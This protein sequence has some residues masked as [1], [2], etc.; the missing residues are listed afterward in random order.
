MYIYFFLQK[1]ARQNLIAVVFLSAVGSCTQ[2]HVEEWRSRCRSVERWRNDSNHVISGRGMAW[3]SPGPLSG[4]FPQENRTGPDQQM[5]CIARIPKHQRLHL[6]S[7][8][9]VVVGQRESCQRTGSAAGFA[10]YF[11]E[12]SQ[13]PGQ[14]H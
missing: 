3:Q 2:M 14:R 10:G 4:L 5:A 9:Y 1:F 6:V 8:F 11:A 7:Y 13:H 12:R